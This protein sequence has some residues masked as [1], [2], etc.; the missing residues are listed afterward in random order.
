MVSKATDML[1]E[2]LA[3]WSD[4]RNV[5]GVAVPFKVDFPRLSKVLIGEY[6]LVVTPSAILSPLLLV[7]YVC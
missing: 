4:F 2:L 3:R 7:V 5:V 6:D 1:D